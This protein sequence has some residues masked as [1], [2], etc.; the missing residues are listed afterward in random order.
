MKKRSNTNLPKRMAPESPPI[1]PPTEVAAVFGS[2]R[3]A[4]PA[5]TIEELNAVPHARTEQMN[6]PIEAVDPTPNPSAGKP[7]TECSAD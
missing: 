6:N 7:R 1:F 4:G 2:L 3:Y 5:K